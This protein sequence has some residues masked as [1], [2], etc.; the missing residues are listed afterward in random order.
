MLCPGLSFVRVAEAFDTP[1]AR[2]AYTQVFKLMTCFLE[3]LA[4]EEGN[5]LFKNLNDFVLR[6][7][8]LANSP[9][10]TV[11]VAEFVSSV[12][13][14]L[15][16]EHESFARER[17]NELSPVF[18]SAGSDDA[19]EPLK[20]KDVD[21]YWNEDF[22]LGTKSASQVF[23]NTGGSVLGDDGEEEDGKPRAQQ[24]N[25]EGATVPTAGD[26]P[27]WDSERL[28]DITQSFSSAAASRRAGRQEQGDKT[29]MLKEFFEASVAA[30][31]AQEPV[32]QPQSEEQRA[33]MCLLS[34]VIFSTYT[35]FA[36]IGLRAT[37]SGVYSTLFPLQ[38]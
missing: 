37:V 16:Q 23:S 10:T 17:I 8:S 19:G 31:K 15:Q 29:Q 4:T 30:A 5:D 24:G 22:V 6:L 33:M 26:L 35:I 25:G 20:K 36:L 13:R 38:S 27:S 3:A 1:E 21:V 18:R 32:R 12:C 11:A 28:M 2:A 7:A 14:A 34:F 9:Q